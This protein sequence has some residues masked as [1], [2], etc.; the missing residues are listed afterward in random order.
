MK[1]PLLVLLLSLMVPLIFSP[2]ATLWAESYQQEY[3]QAGADLLMPD[4]L[5]EL[6]APIALYPDPLIAQILPA[7]TFVDQ[8]GDAARFVRRYGTGRVDYQGWD[9]SVRAIAH[10]PQVLYM[11]DQNPD[12]TASLGQA[13]VEQPQDVMDAI[14]R[15]RDDARAAG[16][17]YT[18]PQQQVIVD[19]GIIS[20]VPARPQYVYLPVYDPYVVYYEPSYPSYPFITFSTG[21][22]IGAW[23][24]RDCDWRRHRVYYHGW[25]GTGWVNRARPHIHDQRGIYINTRASNIRVN[26]RVT[27]RDTRVYRTELRNEGLRWRGKSGGHSTPTRVQTR[28]GGATPGARSETPRQGQPTQPRP[29]RV[30][31]PRQ[32]QPPE[33]RPGRVE[34]QRPGKTESAPSGRT[35]PRPGRTEV[36]PS[37]ASQQRPSRVE[38]HK[39]PAVQQAP[40]ATAPQPATSGEKE[41]SRQLRQ[42][43]RP[44]ATPTTVVPRATIPAPSTSTP[45]ARVLETPPTRPV[46]PHPAARPEVPHPAPR[47][48]A[49]PAPAPPVAPRE[50]APARPSR[51]E[52]EPVEGAGRGVGRGGDGRAEPRGDDRREER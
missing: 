12:W 8:I 29:G 45:P 3:Y 6:L 51:P 52:R 42:I 48:S 13:F 35:Q 50:V 11:L 10:Y 27:Q 9:I 32:G 7:S 39:G 31:T 37:G 28:R 47:P 38:Q 25:R 21:F 43:N 26:T 24:N 40:A 4:E 1:K 2:G 41:R 36:K 49:V 44:P 15:L 19:G 22:V 5:D 20:I 16:N 17:L 46:I 34:Q 23:L 18:T 14:Q 33:P 30:E